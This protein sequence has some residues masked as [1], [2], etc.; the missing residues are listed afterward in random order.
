MDFAHNHGDTGKAQQIKARSG[1][2]SHIAHLNGLRAFAFLA[3]LFF[4]F[5]Y[6]CEGGFL[7]VDVFFVLSGYLMTR[8]IGAQ[9][10]SNNFSYTAFLIRRFWR[11]YPAL[12]CTIVGT[13]AMTFSLFPSDLAVDVARS[14]AASVFG[15]SNL[16]FLAEEGYFGTSSIF[17]P[18]LHTWSLSVEWQF[19]LV[20]PVLMMCASRV[21]FLAFRWPLAVLCCASFWYGVRLSSTEPSA[22]FFTLNGR[23]FEFGLGA[24]GATSRKTVTSAVVGNC[25]SVFGTLLLSLSFAFVRPEHGAP[26]LIALPALSGALLIILSPSHVLC[27]RFYA[28]PIPSYLGKISYSAY[29]VHW[30]VYVF[31]H[32]IFEHSEAPWHVEAVVV[33]GLLLVSVVMYHCVEDKY[34]ASKQPRRTLVG[35][36]LITSVLALSLSSH[37][38]S[39][40]SWRESPRLPRDSLAFERLGFKNDLDSIYMPRKQSLGANDTDEQVMI[41]YIPRNTSKL[42]SNGDTFDALVIGD[43]LSPAL[44]PALH[45]IA[46]ELSQEFVLIANHGCPPFLDSESLDTSM[47]DNR[48]PRLS[49]G[50]LDCKKS[51]RKRTV[52][53]LKATKTDTV[54]LFGG[55]PGMPQILRMRK[56][57]VSFDFER[58][59]TRPPSWVR[60]VSQLEETIALILESGKKVLFVGLVPG[61]HYNVRVCFTSKG[62]LAFLKKCPVFTPIPG[63]PGSY[64][65]RG[66]DTRKA[67]HL[68]MKESPILSS[69]SASGKFAYLDPFLSMCDIQK[70][71]CPLAKQAHVYYSDRQ[72]PSRFGGML[73]KEDLRAALLSLRGT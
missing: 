34:R 23:V 47:W 63:S 68:L 21:P 73:M 12:L 67:F 11:L 18:L 4:H 17:K 58:N 60:K 20:W 6:A 57:S 53:L 29:L 62:P 27:N 31:F 25:M 28:S 69:A 55:W 9:L 42:V 19:Y 39:G 2:S 35:A 33:S 65:R 13:M 48:R 43:S 49:S 37:L 54:I 30:P 71:R 40:W 32:Y 36:S 64:M 44:A 3:V 16:S 15:V 5:K 24:L 51:K 50:Q 41:G 61:S 8:S 10:D 52:D 1:S 72:H 38:T 70:Q 66:T 46:T 45:D 59:V 14:A 26:T 56:E 22:A 7:G